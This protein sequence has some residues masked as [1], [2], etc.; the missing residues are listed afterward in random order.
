MRVGRTYE[1]RMTTDDVIHGFSGIPALGLSGATLSSSTVPVVRFASPTAAHVGVHPFE[2][3]FF[4]GVGHPFS[5]TIQV[6]P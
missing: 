1:L 2:C 3:D 6:V 5:G 4:C